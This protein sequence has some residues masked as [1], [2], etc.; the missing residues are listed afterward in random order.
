M[1]IVSRFIEGLKSK[2]SVVHM[3][4]EWL[5]ED[6][7]NK[8]FA[9]LKQ[10]NDADKEN[11]LREFVE[12]HIYE[13][14]PDNMEFLDWVL[15]NPPSDEKPR[16]LVFETL[17]P[18][19][20]KLDRILR[21]YVASNIHYE[22]LAK[23]LMSA[24]KAEQVRDLVAKNVKSVT[25]G[26]MEYL[27]KLDRTW[28]NASREEFKKASEHLEWVKKWIDP[29]LDHICIGNNPEVLRFSMKMQSA[30][31]EEI[32][33]FLSRNYDRFGE[34][35]LIKFENYAETVGNRMS[36]QF[37]TMGGGGLLGDILD[38]IHLFK[39]EAQQKRKA[40]WFVG[41]N[42]SMTRWVA[43]IV[44]VILGTFVTLPLLNLAFPDIGKY[45]NPTDIWMPIV[46]WGFF[47]Y[48][49]LWGKGRD[50]GIGRALLSG[51]L[52]CLAGAFIG[53]LWYSTGYVIG[54]A[55]GMAVGA[56][57]VGIIATLFEV[58]DV[59]QE[60]G[61]IDWLKEGST[62]TVAAFVSVYL[63]HDLSNREND[64]PLATFFPRIF[65][66]LPTW[67]GDFFVGAT[68]GNIIFLLLLLRF[69][70][71]AGAPLKLSF[72]LTMLGQFIQL[73]IAWALVFGV[74]SYLNGVIATGTLT[75]AGTVA[76]QFAIV[77]FFLKVFA[78][79]AKTNR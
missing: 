60:S 28:G 69:G 25:P 10:C 61:R 31:K 79:L 71:F 35:F 70:W 47:A 39:S 20:E 14:T 26:F 43:V 77:I 15:A 63:F 51:G 78:G 42:E 66:N 38:E 65:P 8:V 30:T 45:V 46:L 67:F 9:F 32:R 76:V 3:R 48:Y 2:A 33:S 68:V 49:Y 72:I 18:L 16:A 6:Y 1:S 74:S 57:V 73:Y 50:R 13:F 56:A 23:Q 27:D 19:R 53:G 64:F 17:T 59:Q 55:L 52:W 54:G 5:S 75:T 37:A 34:I 4:Q 62:F 11:R 12:E 7:Q 21:E 40:G 24:Q 58:I 44:I 22:G 29:A 41:L 36:A